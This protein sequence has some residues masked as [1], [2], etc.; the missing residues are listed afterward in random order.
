[1]AFN[2]R[3]V[4]K[5]PRPFTG[6]DPKEN[7]VAHWR[8]WQDYCRIVGWVA[9][10]DGADDNRVV[11]FVL[12][13]SDAA[14]EW[15]DTL[16][17]G[18]TYAQLEEAFKSRF[19]KLPTAEV[20]MLQL[21]NMKKTVG[22]SYQ[23]FGEKILQK[24]NRV[25]LNDAQALVF[26]KRGVKPSVGQ[27]I[28]AR[29]CTTIPQAVTAAEAIDGYMQV[30]QGTV[31][32]AQP[33]VPEVHF[34]MTQMQTQNEETLKVLKESLASLAKLTLQD[35]AKQSV[36]NR[37][38]TPY[39]SPHR[40]QRSRSRSRSHCDCCRDRDSSRSKSWDS[41]KDFRSRSRPN[42]FRGGT[43]KYR[44]DSVGSS[45]SEASSSVSARSNDTCFVCK[46]KGHWASDC[47]QLQQMHALIAHLN[48]NNP[49]DDR[50]ESVDPQ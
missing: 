8:K 32:Q 35:D 16:V 41:S 48:A 33:V 37:P 18:V 45:T 24:T 29:N 22:E 21:T 12:A 34:A 50:E 42:R 40:N 27:Y 15:Y 31:E 9:P 43:G 6:T 26:F 28:M 3:N 5:P 4:A 7:A 17:E 44:R 14:R 49:E 11:N 23:E 38:R 46:Q 10:A 19:G 25:G 39:Q 30:C 36:R 20:D 1:M 47:T 2:I 13:L